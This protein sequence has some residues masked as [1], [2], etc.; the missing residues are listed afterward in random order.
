[1]QYLTMTPMLC[2]W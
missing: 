2:F 1:M